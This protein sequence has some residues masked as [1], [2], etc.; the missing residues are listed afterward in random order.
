MPKHKQQSV[1]G[2]LAQALPGSS[3]SERSGIAGFLSGAKGIAAGA[4]IALAV[5]LAAKAA[6]KKR[7][8][9]VP[10][11]KRRMPVQQS[12]DIGAPIAQVYNHWIRFE[13][14]PTFMHR[15]IRV[16][17]DD[18][19]PTTVRFAVKIWAKTKEFEAQIQTQRP[20]ERIKWEA[21]QGMTHTGVV[22]FHEL[23]PNLTRVLL[24]M[25]VEPSGL[26]EKAARGMRHIKRAVRG[27]LHRFKALVEMADENVDAW[28][29]TI[30]DGKVTSARSR[31]SASAGSR[32]RGENGTGSRSSPSSSGRGN[33]PQ[34]RSRDEHKR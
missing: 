21:T 6:S 9:P 5:P 20:M 8:M 19:D 18:D 16:E 12:V 14:W 11:K 33:R 2:T 30:E 13:D 25:D 32:R 23:G 4:G 7:R 22:T 29:G 15:V 10:S 31:K 17:H 28:Q 34:S 1:R 26:L 3:K 27:D 24:N